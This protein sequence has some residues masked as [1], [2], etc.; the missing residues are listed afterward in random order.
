[1]GRREQIRRL[2]RHTCVTA[3][4]GAGKTRTL[5]QTYVELLAGV[6]GPALR[7]L[8]PSEIVAITFTDK[9]AEEMRERV[10]AAVA[11]RAAE[12]GGA[13][14][15]RWRGLL[16]LV[17]WAPISTIHSFCAAL[18]REFGVH[19]GLDPDFAVLDQD[20]FDQL[21]GEVMDQ[22]LRQGLAAGDPDLTLAL[23]HY[24]LAGPAALGGVLGQIMAALSTRG[25]GA[26]QAATAT[27]AAFQRQMAR[28]G[29]ALA[30]MERAVAELDTA[31]GGA[32]FDPK[33][34]YAAKVEALLGSWPA[35]RAAIAADPNDAG[36]L[37]ELKALWGGRWSNAL[38]EL[39]KYGAGLAGELISLA[40]LEQGLALSRALVALAG[41]V[42]A[43]LALEQQR[44]SAV[45]F[46][47]LLLLA[48]DLLANYPEV[49][50]E[51]R[52]RWA[53]LLVDEYQDVNPLQGE[54]VELITGA[55]GQG[56]GGPGP[57]AL[58]VGDAK[59][60]IYAF[61]G[62]EVELMHRARASLGSGPGQV[63]ALPENFRSRP[64]LVE[65]FNR[66]F[67][68]VFPDS[69]P[70]EGVTPTPFSEDDRQQAAGG[71]EAPVGPALVVLR[72]QAPEG[73]PAAVMLQ[74][75]A[76]ALARY[77]AG[78]F[79]TGEARPGEVALLLRRLTQ[80]GV[81]ERELTR[82]GVE[83]YTVRGRGFFACQEVADVLHGLQAA[84]DPGNHLALAGLLRS[85][86]VGLSDESLLRLCYPDGDEFRPLGQ[87]VAREEGHGLGPGQAERW[88]AGR[89]M[90]LALRAMAARLTPAELIEE[91]IERS[92]VVPVL[93]ATRQGEQ[94]LANLRKLIESAREPS[95]VLRGSAEEFTAGLARL[96]AEPPQDPQAPLAGEDARVVRIMTVHQAKGLQF[97]VV[98]L[99]D[100]GGGKPPQRMIPPPGPD[101]AVGA[102]PL[103]PATGQRLKH[104]VYQELKAREK[105]V[106]GG[107]DARLFYVAC[108]RAVS[109]L[110]LV[111][112]A[113]AGG[114]KAWPRWA[115]WAAEDPAAVEVNASGLAPDDPGG[116]EP[117]AAAWPDLLPPDPGDQGARAAAVLESALARRHAPRARVS[118]SVSGLEAWLQC[119][120][121]YAWTRRM[122]LDTGALAPA[123]PGGAAPAGGDPVALGSAVHRALELADLWAGP[124]ALEPALDLA[125]LDPALAG[126][127][128]GAALSVARNFWRT[129][130]PAMIG[131][132]SPRAVLREQGFTLVLGQPGA[133]PQVEV[134]GE[135]DLLLAGPEP[136]LV[137]YKV[138]GDIHPEH[139]QDQL[140]IYSMALSKSLGAPPRAALCYL[141]P[142]GARLLPVQF[143]PGE[144]RDYEQR[145]I[146][147]GAEIASLDPL[148]EPQALPPGPGCPQGCALARAGWCRG[149]D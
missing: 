50:S 128:R 66:L 93:L 38:T 3:G 1:M 145:I 17:E 28:R 44:R 83:H 75:E 6:A 21:Q 77:L 39:R 10:V 52:Q 89:D 73:A 126:V 11:R 116:R 109:R 20:A 131:E 80:V 85:P 62:A 88:R 42:A 114:N 108:T 106:G 117:P 112:D 32:K 120:R 123:G 138:T 5:V 137:D 127:D 34:R 60:S 70:G 33:A 25:L 63:V 37:R 86:L 101:G 148:A 132:L 139:Y 57:V 46:D 113:G 58:L 2:A 12:A 76:Q 107:E 96:V 146:R 125:L 8:E 143:S 72:P 115:A 59:Q 31:R 134:I 98:V 147:A 121:L 68:K 55:C 99:A 22:V 65:F 48:R 69:D 104:A 64:E 49:L 36:C 81:F 7:P 41:R 43:E 144:L 47:G 40:G 149:D 78:A 142:G 111:G 118:E 136:L 61:R 15:G 94:K 9:A 124:D 67:A 100:L 97:P 84:L 91:L 54:L 51:L 92:G 19:L 129:D 110:V 35:L 24:P 79:A 140:A 71:P 74:A 13:E 90:L 130:L 23:A 122:G 4:A 95:G 27:E 16:P 82:A 56:P 103:D 102:A 45:S 30:E 53:A 135:L 119:P 18:L 141:W 14:A 87:A 133:L 26:G 105:A 29:Q